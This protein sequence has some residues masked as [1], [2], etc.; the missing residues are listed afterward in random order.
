MSEVKRH[1]DIVYLDNASTTR[2]D[3]RVINAVTGVLGH[4]FGNPS[5]L[6]RLGAR[7]ERL[8]D[9]S[10]ERVARVINAESGEIYFTSGGTEAN[11]WAIAGTV[12][13]R[14]KD[15]HIVS[16]TVE[17]PSVISMLDHLHEDGWEISLIGV[18][19]EGRVD[20]DEI[21]DAV[22]PDTALVSIMF[23]QNEIGT[24][25]ECRE[26]GRRIRGLGPKRPWFHVDA[27]QGFARLPIDVKDW[28][29]D[30]M[31]MSAHKIH[32]IKGAGALYIRKGV[33]LG[34]LVF[35][36]GQESG[37]RSGT[38]N[39]PGIVGFGTA[40]EVWS[41]DREEVMTRLASFRKRLVDGVRSVFPDAVLHGPEDEGVAPHICHFSFPGLRGESI[42]HALEAR[43]VYVSTGSACSSHKTRPS[44][45][46]MALTGNEDEA[47]SAIRF[48]MSR[49]TSE[50]DIDRTVKALDESL[51]EL[52]AWRRK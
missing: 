23:V 18:D 20:P 17:H 27:V 31:S 41:E 44:P 34:P 51:R 28:G 3:P 47:L 32:G 26:I 40:C 11:N 7:A 42:L 15:P 19:E 50:E 4:D 22:T 46:I 39:M 43:D 24:I 35:G 10:R 33:R 5:S 48:S 6:H 36:G 37:L 14:A 38:E 21:M 49:D 8:L 1:E 45:V 16:T 9:E 29:V 2:P 12:A 52:S 13:S 25:Q 30:L